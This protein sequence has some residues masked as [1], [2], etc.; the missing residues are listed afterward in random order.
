MTE[1]GPTLELVP[2]APLGLSRKVKHTRLVG[3]AVANSG[4]EEERTRQFGLH[5][6][7]QYDTK[8]RVTCTAMGEDS[9]GGGNSTSP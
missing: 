8:R 5:I 6:L 2:C 9:D 4:L 1:M 3:V 7:A